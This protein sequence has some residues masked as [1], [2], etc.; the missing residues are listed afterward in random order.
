MGL[1]LVTAAATTPITTAEAKKQAGIDF[2][3]DDTFVDGLVAAAVRYCEGVNDVA[4]VTQTWKL[5]LDRF[6]CDRLIELPKPPLASITHVKYYDSANA[7][8]TWSSALYEVS[9]TDMPGRLS[10]VWGES[11]P[12]TYDRINAVEIQFVCGYGAASAVP[13]SYKLALALLVGHWYR[14]REAVGQ[15]GDR[16]ALAVD[17]LLGVEWSG[18]HSYQ[19]HP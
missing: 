18:V 14:N 10:P 12:G 2:S 4:M 19:G 5:F 3:D 8:Q 17:S 9:A 13:Q 7:L 11:W 16:I 6:P 15:V 1:S